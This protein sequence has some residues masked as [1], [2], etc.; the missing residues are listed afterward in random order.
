MKGKYADLS[1]RL[2]INL[3]VIPLVILIIAYADRAWGSFVLLSVMTF[4]VIVGTV[5][6]NNLLAKK[7]IELSAKINIL[8]SVLML[9]SFYIIFSSQNKDIKKIFPLLMVISASIFFI[10]HFKCINN[11]SLH[12]STG[13]FGICYVVGPFIWMLAIVFLARPIV[14]GKLLLFYL[15]AMTKI[16]DIGGYFFGKFLGSHSLAPH[17][18]PSKTVEGAI[19]GILCTIILS[20]LSFSFMENSL[21]IAISIGKRILIGFL[22]ALLSQLGDLLESLLK[23]D[24]LVKDSNIIP[25]VGGVL[26]MIDSFTFTA[27]AVYFWAQS[28]YY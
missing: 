13:F 16:N 17:L 2:L 10:S 6:Y 3:I 20:V 27:P 19:G 12:V 25:G 14:I 24:A 4:L 22:L 1:H 8:F 21:G 26:D 15:I 18:S 11:A 23:R 5:E 28:I 7:K 9:F